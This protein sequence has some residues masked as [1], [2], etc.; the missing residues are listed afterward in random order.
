MGYYDNYDDFDDGDINFPGYAG[1]HFAA[2]FI[3][4]A[5]GLGFGFL[6]GFSIKFCNC[7]IAMRYFNDSEFFDVSES[8]RFPW[9]DENIRLELEYN[10]GNM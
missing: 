7:N 9:K 4:I 3:S 8:D 5:T 1:K 10:P 2:I 6:A